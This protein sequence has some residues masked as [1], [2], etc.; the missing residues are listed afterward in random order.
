M[1]E[2]QGDVQL[3]NAPDGGDIQV[4][5][6]IVS[7]DGGL[8]TAAYLSLFGGNKNDDGSQDNSRTWWGNLSETGTVKQYRSETQN[9]LDRIPLISGNLIKVQLAAERDLAWFI[10]TKVAS[11]V[12]VSATIPALNTIRIVVGIEAFGEQS[13]FTFTENWNS[14]V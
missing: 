5:G 10:D 13:Q 12:I 2:Q 11:S 4:S 6:G 7:M 3:F 9:L 1:R 14:T 8:E